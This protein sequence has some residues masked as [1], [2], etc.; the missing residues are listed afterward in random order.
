MHSL[1]AQ[2]YRTQLSIELVQTN[3]DLFYLFSVQLLWYAFND[4]EINSMENAREEE[5]ANRS[6]DNRKCARSFV[7]DYLPM[8]YSY[9]QVFI[10]IYVYVQSETSYSVIREHVK[11]RQRKTR[12]M[13]I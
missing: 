10:K 13:L 2:L 4:S 3:L 5:H 12:M 6:I 1:L 7:S 8:I 11:H 9:T